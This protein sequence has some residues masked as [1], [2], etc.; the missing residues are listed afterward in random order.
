MHI[1]QMHS[2]KRRRKRLLVLIPLALLVAL[3]LWHWLWSIGVVPVPPPWA[4]P[5]KPASYPPVEVPKAVNVILV[6]DYFAQK[7]GYFEAVF[8]SPGAVVGAYGGSKAQGNATAYAVGVT[9]GNRTYA[10]VGAASTASF[11]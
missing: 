3:L 2:Q 9:I 1:S 7:D 5:K 6:E 4:K 10:I 11:W 8:T